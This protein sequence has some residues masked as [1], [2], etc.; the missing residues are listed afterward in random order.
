M[1]F[2]CFVRC[3]ALQLTVIFFLELQI[4]QITGRPLYLSILESRGIFT[5]GYWYRIGIGAMIA[6]TVLFNV[7]ATLALQH[8]N[9]K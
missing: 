8:L 4:R 6:Y 7:L 1:L 3:M 2:E 5:R 9:R